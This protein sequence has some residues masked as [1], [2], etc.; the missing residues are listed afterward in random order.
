MNAAATT[1]MVLDVAHDFGF[2]CYQKGVP[3]VENPYRWTDKDKKWA[4]EMGHRLGEHCEKAQGA[5]RIYTDPRQ[6]ARFGLS[7]GRL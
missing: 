6:A 1:Q 5:D 2:Q 3:L 7:G 4:W